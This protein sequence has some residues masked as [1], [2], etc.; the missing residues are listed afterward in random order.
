MLAYDGEKPPQ[1]KLRVTVTIEV[2]LDGVEPRVVPLGPFDVP[3][4]ILPLPSFLLLA[5][6]EKFEI[7]E[8]DGASNPLDD[9]E[10]AFWFVAPPSG[11]ETNLDSR[12]NEATRFAFDV[13]QEVVQT[14]GDGVAPA[15]LGLVD[16]L[17][18]A[19]PVLGAIQTVQNVDS[20]AGDC[21]DLNKW[22]LPNFAGED[23]NDEIDALMLFATP[24]REVKLY[25]APDYE[26][27]EGSLVLTASHPVGITV[28]ESLITTTPRSFP[29][30][31]VEVTDADTDNF[32]DSLSSLKWL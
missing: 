15:A 1:R 2:S 14:A 29:V 32:H 20:K 17:E 19:A 13:V 11:D 16:L 28:V 18:F 3:T 10:T 24:G 22:G 27:D 4:V 8:A 25:C 23:A 31:F 6:E 30:E 5:T 9:T 21:S 26:L 12:A 7:V